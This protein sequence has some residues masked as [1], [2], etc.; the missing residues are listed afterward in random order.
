VKAMHI[1]VVDDESALR[2]Q[3]RQTLGRQQYRV[4]TAANG[5]EA[6]DKLCND[7]YDLVLLDI[8]MPGL[9]GMAVLREMR[10][11]GLHTPV[12]M[13]TA[14]GDTDDRVQGLDQGADDYLAKPF[15]MAELLARIRSLLR[16]Q[17]GRDPVMTVGHL[18]LDTVSRTVTSQGHPVPLTSK[19]FAILEFLFYN[20]GR[21]VS[22][23]NLAEH[24]W[25]DDFDPFTMSNF[26]DVHMKNMRKKTA[27][28]AGASIVRTI[29]GVGY[30]IDGNL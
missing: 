22:R 16:R 28:A 30:I 27:D 8:M 11:V 14:R 15:S 1:L 29:R 9:D 4:D 3:L 18:T 21:A 2:D 17:G 10:R 23:F 19:E 6:L 26:I 5:E 13:L 12:L 25:G 20:Q 24:V 7:T